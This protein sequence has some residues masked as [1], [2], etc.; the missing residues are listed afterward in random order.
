MATHLDSTLAGETR[1]TSNFRAAI[2][3]M[4]RQAIDL[5]VDRFEGPGRAWPHSLR[6]LMTTADRIKLQF[7]A[8]EVSTVEALSITGQMSNALS[9][10]LLRDLDVEDY[11]V[12]HWEAWYHSNGNLRVGKRRRS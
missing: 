1:E 7:D 5:W 6:D 2:S 11:S 8:A 12:E 3:E 10:T 4:P 9:A